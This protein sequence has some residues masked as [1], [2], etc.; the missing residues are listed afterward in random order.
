MLTRL[1]IFIK[2]KIRELALLS[3]M[4]AFDVFF[5]WLTKK[6]RTKRYIYELKKLISPVH[7]IN[8]Y[9]MVPI[10]IALQRLYSQRYSYWWR[11]RSNKVSFLYSKNTIAG[12]RHRAKKIASD[13][14]FE[15]NRIKTRFLYTGLIPPVYRKDNQQFQ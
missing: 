8:Y 2:M 1:W 12:K 6:V 11:N 15:I 10:D 5:F 13:F 3:L 14:Q 7:N 9:L 4:A